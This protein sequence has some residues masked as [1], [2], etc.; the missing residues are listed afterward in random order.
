MKK[1]LSEAQSNIVDEILWGN[2]FHGH[3]ITSVLDGEPI[4]DFFRLYT[5][6][7]KDEC[8]EWLERLVIDYFSRHE[9]LEDYYRID[10]AERMKSNMIDS[11]REMEAA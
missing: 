3:D 4:D 8:D 10:E 11:K 5:N 2:S 7:K 1:W 9:E 6:R